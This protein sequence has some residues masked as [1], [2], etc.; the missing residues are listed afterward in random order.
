MPACR[1]RIGQIHGG[2][3][4]VVASGSTFEVDEI[5]VAAG[6]TP[7][8]T[9]SGWSESAS[10][11]ARSGGYLTTMTT[12][13]WSEA[14]LALRGRRRQRAGAAH[15]HGQV[16]GE[17]RGRRDRRA[18]RGAVDRRPALP[19]RCRPRHRARGR[20]LAAAGGVS[21]SQRGDRPRARR[22]RAGAR[23]RRSRRFGGAASVLRDGT[24]APQ[25]SSS[26]A[27]ATRWWA[28]RSSARMSPSCC[29]RPRSRSSARSRSRRSRTRSPHMPRSARSGCGSLESRD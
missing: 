19:R 22:R 1:H 24:P 25:S 27:R 15:A 3:A 21:G 20:V 2:P 5:V 11:S 10:T 6:G 13:R 28:R 18:R 14:R 4:K 29:L 9:T 26:T 8:P 12:W 7:P 23:V 17:D 16:P